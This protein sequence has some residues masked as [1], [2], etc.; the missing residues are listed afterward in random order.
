MKGKKGQD[1]AF[2][3]DTRA[4]EGSFK[5]DFSQTVRPLDGNNNEDPFKGNEHTKASRMRDF[6]G[7]CIS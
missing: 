5:H 1:G 6:P 4:D 2:C 7:K 3:R